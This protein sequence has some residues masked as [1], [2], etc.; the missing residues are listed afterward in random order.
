MQYQEIIKNKIKQIP[1]LP[2]IYKMLD[3]ANNIIYIGKSKCLKKRVQSYFTGSPTWEKVSRMVTMIRDIEYIVTDTHLEARLL[4][5]KL[6]KEV[7]PR[8]NAQMKNDQRYIFLK[9]EP[10]NLYNP[11]SVVSERSENCFGPFRSKFKISEFLSSMKNI[12]PIALVND[13]FEIE[14]HMFPVSMDREAFELNRQLLLEL[15]TREDYLL[16]FIEAM[17]NKL[18]EAAS[19][20]RYEVALSYRDMIHS[21]TVIKNGLDGYKSL[22]VKD[23]LLK[24]PIPEGYKLFFVSCGNIINS[25]ITPELSETAIKTFIRDSKT[26]VAELCPIA[27]NEK[28]GI[29]YRDILYSEISGLPDDMVIL[30]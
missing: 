2:G 15:F 7:K 25:R 23:I 5:C 26:N 20:Y 1:E 14:Y 10:Y 8:F 21:L 9:V 29:D 4:E 3:S 24:L 28:S 16:S 6:I 30:L 13:C 22:A 19:E 17:K 27:D 18:Q 11:L 12:Y